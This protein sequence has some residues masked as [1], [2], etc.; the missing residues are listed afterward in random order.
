MLSTVNIRACCPGF[1]K[2]CG[3]KLVVPH[4][5]QSKEFNEQTGEPVPP[6]KVCTNPM[7]RPIVC[8]TQEVTG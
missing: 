8:G 4:G 3:H 1:C 5:L 6:K 7:C 2:C